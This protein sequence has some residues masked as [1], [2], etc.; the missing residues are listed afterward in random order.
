MVD[1]GVNEEGGIMYEDFVHRGVNVGGGVLLFLGGFW[2]VQGRKVITGK[3]EKVTT[4][5]SHFCAKRMWR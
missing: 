3:W 4:S 1:I 5:V 2:C